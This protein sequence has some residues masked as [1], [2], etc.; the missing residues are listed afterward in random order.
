MEQKSLQEQ[1]LQDRQFGVIRELLPALLRRPVGPRINLDES[2]EAAKRSILTSLLRM[3]SDNQ[4]RLAL[5]TLAFFSLGERAAM[6]T[7]DNSSMLMSGVDG[8]VLMPLVRKTHVGLLGTT[9]ESIRF[10]ENNS[11][12]S[13]DTLPNVTWLDEDEAVADTGLSTTGTRA[14]TGYSKGTDG[15]IFTRKLLKQAKGDLVG[16]LSQLCLEAHSQEDQRV[17]LAG[18]GVKEPVGMENTITTS[19]DTVSGLT[20][21]HLAQVTRQLL[22]KGVDIKR[23]GCMVDSATFESWL[24]TPVVSGSDRTF[25]QRDSKSPTGYSLQGSGGDG[26][27]LGVEPGLTAGVAIIGDYSKSRVLVNEKIDLIIVPGVGANFG[28]K[29]Q[30]CIYSFEDSDN[31]IDR[32]EAFIK[33]INL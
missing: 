29:A 26:I 1:S 7:T 16:H 15:I 22:D 33:L 27:S 9:F 28:P 21:S 17:L 20:T 5:D 14:L 4:S 23:L 11:V 8:E 25:A 2:D 31:L 6:N 24:E 13:F 12:A 10:S 30:T 32:E 3:R 18:D 19:I